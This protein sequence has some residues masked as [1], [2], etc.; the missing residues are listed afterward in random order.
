MCFASCAPFVSGCSIRQNSA[1]NNCELFKYII[2]ALSKALSALDG[3]QI[4]LLMDS[5]PIHIAETVQRELQKASFLPVIV[6]PGTTG[7]LQVPDTHIFSPF[8]AELRE[9]CDKL[10][11]RLKGDMTMRSYVGCVGA[12]LDSV[13]YGRSWAAAF[14]QNGYARDQVGVS[15]KLREVA[16]EPVGACAPSAAELALCCPRKRAAAADSLCRKFVQSKGGDR[17]ERQAVRRRGQKRHATDALLKELDAK[18]CIRV[19][20]AWAI[21]VCCSL[22][23]HGQKQ[24]REA[25]VHDR[26]VLFVLCCAHRA[27]RRDQG[28]CHEG[29]LSWQ[30]ARTV[31]GPCVI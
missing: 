6:P 1:W 13:L 28:T 11:G 5:L 24:H 15:S 4:V 17:D 19:L 9:Q 20:V 18:V 16:L 30:L 10:R 3:V 23:A 2:R 26:R 21:V 31:Y 12:A 25:R 8:K 29:V 22:G 7:K 14:A 27:A